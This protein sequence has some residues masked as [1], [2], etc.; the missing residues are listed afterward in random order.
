MD[1]KSPEATETDQSHL[2]AVR[3]LRDWLRQEAGTEKIPRILGLLAEITQNELERGH[4]PP[5][6]AVDKLAELYFRVYGGELGQGGAGRWLRRPDVLRWWEARREGISQAGM[7]AGLMVLPDL[8]SPPTTGS[9]NSGIYSFR[10]L[11]VDAPVTMARPDTVEQ[12]PVDTAALTYMMAPAKAAIWLGWLSSVP[13]FPMLSW[14]GYLLIALAFLCLCFL[15]LVWIVGYLSLRAARP[16]S[17]ADLAYLAMASSLT[18]LMLKGLLPILRLHKDRV[19]VVP[20]VMLSLN[21]MHGQFNQVRDMTKKGASGWFSLV[22]YWGNCPIC[23]GEVEVLNGGK[24]FPG[25]LVGRCS[26]SPMEHVFSFDPVL[27]AGRKL[28]ER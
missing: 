10:F 6:Q 17:T 22:R 14:R 5:A 13:R 21:Q 20:D 25:R 4:Q 8:V 28:R 27:L 2:C 3:W 19:T 1:G 18:W 26:D 23:S 16:L 24:E 9:G 15:V 12:L 7:R 11:S